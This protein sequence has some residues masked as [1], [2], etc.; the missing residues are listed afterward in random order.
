[1]DR[2]TREEESMSDQTMGR[3]EA[4]R[5]MLFVLGAAAV[6]PSALTACGGEESGS[7]AGALRCTD[8][9]GLQPAEL[10]MRQSQAY[11]DAS[12]HSDKHCNNCRFYQAGQPNQC[13]GC[14]VIRG[15]IHP[16]G[17]CNLWAANA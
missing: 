3:R 14:Q 5:R 11:A 16:Q 15:Q 9:S 1:M 10:T 8:T 7:G 17:Y 6:A 2:E 12:P 13:G 4:T